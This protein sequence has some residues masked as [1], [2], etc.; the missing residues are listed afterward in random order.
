EPP[1]ALDLGCA[2]GQLQYA[3]GGV[4][5]VRQGRQ[6]SGE[7]ELQAH[8][9]DSGRDVPDGAEHSGRRQ[10]HGRDDGGRLRGAGEAY[11]VWRGADHWGVGTKKKPRP[12]AE[13]G[14]ETAVAVKRLLSS[15]SPRA[16]RGRPAWGPPSSRGS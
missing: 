15:P 16:H 9:R 7:A 11:G 14:F 4:R 12:F 2:H 13:R 5:D 6:R 3:P 1:A 10:L 8:K